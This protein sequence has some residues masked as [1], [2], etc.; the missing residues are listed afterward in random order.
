[1]DT[2]YALLALALTLTSAVPAWAGATILPDA[3]GNDKVSFDVTKQKAKTP[4]T[5]PGEGKAQVIFI[6][7]MHRPS[8]FSGS[9]VGDRTTRFGLDGAWVGATKSNSYFTVDIAPGEHHMCLSVK[10]SKDMIETA[11]FTAEAGKIYYFEYKIDVTVTHNGSAGHPHSESSIDPAMSKL[12]E[13]QGKFRV[14]S[15]DLST[16]VMSK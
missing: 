15:S 1:M 9:I 3:C 14:K 6:E 12:E 8:F 7:T 5:A 11:A 4:P 16:W 13:D 2:K 10:G